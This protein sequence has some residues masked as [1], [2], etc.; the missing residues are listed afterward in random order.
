[1]AESCKYLKEMSYA[2]VNDPDNKES[3]VENTLKGIEGDEVL[4]LTHPRGSL[5]FEKFIPYFTKDQIN[6]LFGNIR[7]KLIEIIVDSYASRVL[8]DLYKHYEVL[9][10]SIAHDEITKVLG[11]VTD[12]FLEKDV[13]LSQIFE[14]STGAHA[15]AALL[16]MIRPYSS[17]VKNFINKVTDCVLPEG[18]KEIAVE[19]IPIAIE[20]M[21]IPESRIRSVLLP[22]IA[23]KV[24]ITDKDW[25]ILVEGALTVM[26][27]ATL[28]TFGEKQITEENVVD[29][30]GNHVVQKYLEISENPKKALQVCYKCIAEIVKNRYHML[31]VQMLK[32]SQKCDKTVRQELVE[33]IEG[34]IC[35]RGNVF[36]EGR[37]EWMKNQKNFIDYGF[38]V[39]FQ[40]IFVTPCKASQSVVQK[41]TDLKIETMLKYFCDPMGSRLSEAYISVLPRNTVGELLKTLS[42]RLREIACNKSG[43]HIVDKIFEKCDIKDKEAMVKEY[44]VD[45]SVMEK[46]FFGRK[47]LINAKVTD[48]RTDASKWKSRINVKEKFKKE[49]SK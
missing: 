44:M 23:N 7:E 47:V 13:N 3:I 38:S 22:V 26:D 14:A 16:R 10:P 27:Q 5:L 6:A 21:K 8:E 18:S 28:Q 19:E 15:F 40:E 17:D 41:F 2:L 30:V 12:P 43:S 37:K 11:I 42:G 4:L 48:Y 33:R 32:A 39:V 46:D 34:E 29:P 49:F 35:G 20:L 9:L 36:E 1:M 31:L 24:P 25:S 45:Y